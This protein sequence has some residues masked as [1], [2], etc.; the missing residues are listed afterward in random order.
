MLLIISFPIPNDAKCAVIKYY[1]AAKV[2]CSLVILFNIS[3]FLARIC[4]S[5][6][7]LLSAVAK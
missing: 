2:Y 4:N 7:V 3:L 1:R 6:H 5:L